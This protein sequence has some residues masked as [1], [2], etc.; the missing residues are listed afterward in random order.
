MGCDASAARP[1]APQVDANGQRNSSCV[2]NQLRDWQMPLLKSI[3]SAMINLR[4]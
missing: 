4:A 2:S 3:P 1:Y